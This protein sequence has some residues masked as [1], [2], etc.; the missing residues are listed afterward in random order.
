MTRKGRHL[1][2][3][4]YT[5]SLL[6][7][8]VAVPLGHTH[9]SSAAQESNAHP[10]HEDACIDRTPGPKPHT[11][12]LVGLSSPAVVAESIFLHTS[13]APPGATVT[14][15]LDGRT[16]QT[17]TQPPFWLGGQRNGLP[18][19][20]SVQSLPTGD[21]QI[22]AIA[23]T[24]GGHKLV[25]ATLKL[26]V[27]S[28]I[29]GHLSPTLATYANQLT[30][31]TQTI[32]SLLQ[33]SSTPGARMS[34]EE[35]QIRCAVLAMYKNWGIDP[36]L[37]NESDTSLTLR[38][39][40]PDRWSSE[41]LG[42]VD[43]PLSLRMSRDAPFYQKIPNDWPRVELP[44]LYIQQV[45]LSTPYG[46]DGIGYGE[47]IAQSS[48]TQLPIVSQWYG[49]ER[50]RKTYV[51]RMPQ[52]W[53]HFLPTQ[54]PG[55]SHMLFVDLEAHTFV[56]TYK[57]TMDPST[58][59]ARALFASL[60][61]SFSTLGD[62]GGSN[63]AGI[64]ELPLLIQ[65]GEATDANHPIRHAIGGAV[66]RAWATRVYPANSWDAKI[67]TSENSCTQR[68]YTNTGLLPYGG[69][70][71]L[72]PSVDLKSLKVSLPARR[73]LEAMQTFGFYVLDFGCA[74]LDIYSAVSESEFEPYGGLWGYNRKGPGVQNE[75]ERVLTEHR[76]YVVPPLMKKQ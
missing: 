33:R 74:D 32:S 1:S 19:G 17:E 40:A 43:A 76:L 50:T 67:R 34:S 10:V 71:Q 58:R 23:R 36:T 51:F 18:L 42:G 35:V 37:D 26:H 63:A 30:A 11:F 8:L 62:R 44:S 55:D 52:N 4:R 7:A 65:P 13:E 2:L 66:N 41:S 39:L 21:H 49:N 56:S 24:N 68:G 46:G 69:V 60:P 64:A 3:R 45:Q 28:S 22:Y 31:Q 47:V 16:L 73:I 12:A 75:I 57:T 20:Y 48:D 72:D 29:N 54:P 59:G 25:S 38:R 5:C 70:L 14:F 15:V 9:Y 53:S 27:I 6:V 61:I